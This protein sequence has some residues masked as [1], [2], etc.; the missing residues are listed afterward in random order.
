MIIIFSNQ[1]VAFDADGPPLFQKRTSIWRAHS[2]S[3]PPKMAERLTFTTRASHVLSL[4]AP[5]SS[6]ESGRWRYM[7][8]SISE[9]AQRSFRTRGSPMPSCGGLASLAELRSR[10]RRTAASRKY[11]TISKTLQKTHL[12]HKP[13]FH[14]RNQLEKKD[15]EC[16]RVLSFFLKEKMY[17]LSNHLL[18]MIIIF[19]NHDNSAQI[20]F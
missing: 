15:I 9:A 14:W 10:L 7:Y 16:S 18:D 8:I 12:K 4:E 19:S 11:Q 17:Q 3:D 1:L 6:F 13:L 5:P 20:M 2:Y